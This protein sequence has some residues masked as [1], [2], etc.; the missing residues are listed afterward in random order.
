MTSRAVSVCRSMIAIVCMALSF[1]L[2]SQ[3]AFAVAHQ[4]EHA[5]HHAHNHALLPDD[6]LGDIIY[7][8]HEEH[9]AT[10]SNSGPESHSETSGMPDYHPSGTEHHHGPGPVD[11]QHG[12]S[13]IVFLI[14]QN[15][16]L[17]NCAPPQL[18]CEF[19]TQSLMTFSPSGPD[20]P[21]KQDL[22]IRA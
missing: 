18:R 4:I 6:F 3:T 19:V 9:P 16:T 21:P 14:S 10:D 15:L 20:H 12:D 11:H 1:L 17:I 2:S 8:T 13:L 22:E 7:L 5:H